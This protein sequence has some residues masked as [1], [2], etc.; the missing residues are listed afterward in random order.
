MQMLLLETALL[1]GGFF[2]FIYLSAGID[3]IT[4][5]IKNLRKRNVIRIILKI[6]SFIVIAAGVLFTFFLMV[7]FSYKPEKD[8]KK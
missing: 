7:L 4:S 3:A 2:L 6:I 5:G 1:I 8:G